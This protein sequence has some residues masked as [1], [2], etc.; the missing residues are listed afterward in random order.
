M[1]SALGAFTD[2]AAREA[3]HRLETI[4]RDG[5]LDL[6]EEACRTLE[7][8][9]DRLTLSLSALLAM[10]SPSDRGAN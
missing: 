7:C 6:A 5:N 1:R 3:A 10:Y 2:G 9:M 4:G 8:E